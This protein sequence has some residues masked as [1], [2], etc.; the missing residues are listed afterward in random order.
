MKEVFFFLSWKIT[1]LGENILVWTLQF[2]S[3]VI[4]VQLNNLS[5]L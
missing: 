4:L 5:E 2:I 3:Y 1:N